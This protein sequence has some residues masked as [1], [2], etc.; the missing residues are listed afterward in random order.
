MCSVWANTLTRSARAQPQSVIPALR[1]ARPR[2]STARPPR[3]GS[4]SPRAPPSG[5]ARTRAGRSGRG[6]RRAAAAARARTPSRRPCRARCAGRRPRARR[7]A[8][9]SRSNRPGACSPPVAS[10][11]GCAVA[12]PLRQRGEQRP[13]TRSPARPAARARDRLGRALAADAAGGR[14]VEAPL[15]P[16][17]VELGASNSTMFA[18]RSAGSARAE[19]LEPSPI[20]EAERELLVVPRRPHR[21][22]NGSPSTRISSGSSTATRSSSCA[23]AGSRVTRTPAVAPGHARSL[24]ASSGPRYLRLHHMLRPRAVPHQSWLHVPPRGPRPLYSR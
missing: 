11:V 21:H 6:S 1:P 13:T 4:G 8:S 3:R 7:G 2:G 24:R 20:A 16:L 14:G 15:Q 18:A 12:E 10:N 19:R 5:R 23:P 22:R 9:P 17:G